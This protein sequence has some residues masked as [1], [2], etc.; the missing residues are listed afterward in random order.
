MYSGGELGIEPD[1][2]EESRNEDVWDY[3]YDYLLETGQSYLPDEGYY[4]QLV[5]EMGPLC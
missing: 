3:E 2:Y 4:P 1:Q 5:D